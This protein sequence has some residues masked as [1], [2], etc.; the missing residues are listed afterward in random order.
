M[1]TKADFI[2]RLKTD[3]QFRQRALSSES[4]TSFLEK[5]GY[6]FSI[7]ELIQELPKVRTFPKVRERPV[8]R[9]L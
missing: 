6:Y 2:R 1:K 9:G 3:T 4:L 8:C 5:E 7:E